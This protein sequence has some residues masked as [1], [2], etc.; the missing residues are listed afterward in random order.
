MTDAIDRARMQR[1]LDFHL[2]QSMRARLA[3]PFAERIAADR[4]HAVA[5]DDPPR[6]LSGSSKLEP[7]HAYS[8]FSLF[9]RNS[10]LI[11]P[12]AGGRARQAEI[13]AQGLAGVVPWKQTA[14]LPFRHYVPTQ[15]PIR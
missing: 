7:T 12:C 2:R 8:F 3:M 1:Q 14:A 6:G 9:G 15:L 10:R 13:F 5:F 11:F 4:G